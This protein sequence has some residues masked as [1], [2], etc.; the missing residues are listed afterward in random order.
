V[1]VGSLAPATNGIVNGI[2]GTLNVTGNGS[3]TLNVDD[4]G[5]TG[6]KTGTLTSTSLTG[7]A[8]GVGGINYSGLATLNISLGS[9][10][11]TFT[12]S[13]TYATTVTTLNSGSGADTVNVLTDSDTTNINSQ[14]GNDTINIQTAGGTTNVNTGTGTNTVNV[15]SL[16]PATGGVLAGLQGTSLIGVQGI[17]NVTGSGNDTLNADDTGDTVSSVGTLTASRLVGLGMGMGGITYSGLAVLN[18]NLGSGSDFFNVFGTNA[19]TV[20]NLNTGAGVNVILVSNLT[21]GINRIVDGIQGTLNVIGSGADVM[22]V[23]DTGSTVAKT[24]TLTSTGLTGLAMG[25]GGINYSGLATLNIS[26]GSGGNTFTISSTYVSTVTTLNSGSGADTVNVLADSDTTNINGQDGNDTINIQTTGATTNV[27]T[28]AGVNTVNVGSLMPTVGGIAD[29]I[30]GTVNVTGNGTDTMNVDDTGS[31]GAKTGTLTSTSLTGLAMGAGGINYSGLATL[32]ISLGSGGNTFTISSTK[33]T[34]VTTLNS[35]SG[36]DTVNVLSDAGVT[37]INGQGGNDTINIRTTGAITNVNTGAGVNVVNVGSLAPTTG[38]IVDGIQG[39]VNVTGSGMDTINVDDT[40]STVAKTGTLTSTSLTGLAMG[41]GGITYS[42]LAKLNINLGSGSDTFNVWSTNATTSTDVLT[43][44][45]VNTVNVGSLTPAVGGVVDGIQGALYVY[46]SGVDIMNVDDTGST[47]AKTGTLTSTSLTGLA[48]G[49]RG[50]AYSGLAKLNISL[51]SGGN[52]FTISSTKNTTVT[53]LNSGSGAD[54]VNVLTDAGVTNIN[55]QAGN[56]TINI[57]TTGAATNVNTG[58]GMNTVNVGSLAPAAAGI[59]DGI[60]GTLNV[61]GNGSDT[62]NVDDTGSTVAKT[63]TLTSTGLTGL[64]MGAGGINYSGLAALNISLGSGGNT[65]AISST[66]VSTVTTL[67]GG[68]GADTV[69]VLADSG[70]TN[71]NGQAGNDTINIRTTGATTNVNTGAGVNTVNVGSLAPPTGGILNNIQGTLNVTGNG[72]DTMNVDDTGST[73]AKTGTLTSTSLTGLAMGAGGINYS[74]LAALN[75]SLGSGGNTFA[76]SSTYVSTVT[77][78]NS[79]SGA[80]TVNV[81]A[82]SGVTNINGQGGNDTINIQ[83]TGATTNVNTGAGVNTVNVGS[84][85]P[86]TGGIVDGIQGTLNVTGNGADTMN[87]D[88]TGS[89]VAKTGTL[90]ST[91]LTGL[92]MGAGGVNYT[93]LVAL[94]ILL[95]SYGNTF[96]IAGTSTAVTHVSS[97]LGDDTFNVAATTGT[98]YLYGDGG[99]NTFNLGSLAPLTGG[100]V[101]GIAGAL[102]ITGGSNQLRLMTLAS[103]GTNTINVDDTGD[104]ANSTGLLTSSTL[105]GL[106]LGVGVTFVSINVMNINLGSGSD[107]FNV[108]ATNAR[109]ITN[110]NTGAGVN[111]VNV[112]SLAPA[113]GGVL[114]TIQGT[115]NVTGN[116][117]DT[118]NVDDTGVTTAMSGTLTATG[119][120]GLGLGA[121]GVNYSDLATLNIS[122]GSYGN[123]FTIA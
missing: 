3:D 36:A 29:G 100:V 65:F 28:G 48:M 15:G 18:I 47:G 105:T 71:I 113:T 8:M 46:G 75:I 43:G 33:N 99:N 112:G 34:T 60:Q 72:T 110:L 118:L 64:A 50:I 80:D 41:V 74:G 68:S 35:G 45:G 13:S 98:L 119:L 11:N 70:V 95:G 106:G 85:T 7:L 122:L 114:N 82:D 58:T 5:S 22:N 40:G 27:N 107:V 56:D 89:T 116:G 62:L 4:T 6:A 44:A 32:N 101:S 23:D 37:N 63:G 108:Q 86:G 51:G 91:G 38:G 120:T 78:L 88:D 92:A 42:G 66:Y 55:G 97:G 49:A 61:T 54:T 25:V 79:G 12:I 67:N 39:T 14:S 76:I 30:Q 21:P 94:N 90:T 52:M 57:R 19:T 121:G 83:T 123:T 109:T 81:L 2:Q 10:G 73:V 115:L 117:S 59:V 53:T 87:V 104:T 111:T 103:P 93:G 77:T 96:T 26:L 31:T 102:Y 1:N 69:N 24:G 84:A 9:G 20:T 16:A 17:L